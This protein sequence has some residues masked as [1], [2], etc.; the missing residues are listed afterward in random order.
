M[1]HVYA[2]AAM[3]LAFFA[4]STGAFAQTYTA[5]RDGNWNDP[6]AGGPWDP[7]G[8]PSSTCLNCTITIN[9]GVTVTLNAHVTLTGVSTFFIGSNGSAPAK[10]L[11]PA[12]GGS[13]FATSFNLILSSAGADLAQLKLLYANT[14]VDASAATTRDGVF[15]FSNSGILKKEIGTAPWQ[16]FG[17]DGSTQLTGT[18]QGG[19]VLTGPT[20][21]NGLGTLPVVLMN[22]TAVAENGVVALNWA[23]AQESNS[24]HFSVERSTD[25]GSHWQILGNVAAQ[26]YSSSQVNYSFS[27]QSPVSG[28][29]QYRLLAVDRDGKSGYSIIKVVRT[30]LISGVSV[31]PNPAKDYVNVSIG[32]E[33]TSGASIRLINQAGQTLAQRKLSGAAGTTV[34]L[35][36]SSYPQGN[37]LI[38][39][40]GADGS[41][42]TSKV[43]ISR[44]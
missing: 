15:S 34:S 4:F 33:T 6:S 19:S 16:V 29:N 5:V 35:P 2:L 9:S 37:Y 21:I 12:S 11:I 43:F 23:T 17:A 39:V 8:I 13:D 1:K 14:S 20:T 22:F 44:Q 24:D 38:V 30:N 26:G 18:I 41:Q 10:L 27:D 31:Y 3:L 40:T 32:T 7:S 25:N 36:V 28:V 42:Q